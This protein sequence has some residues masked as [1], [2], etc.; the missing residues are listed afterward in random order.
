MSAAAL[1]HRIA[2]VRR[3]N[4]FYTQKIGVLA[5]AAEQPVSLTEARVL[6]SSR[7]ATAT[8]PSCAEISVSIPATSADLPVFGGAGWSRARRPR[9][10][11]GKAICH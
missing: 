9:W 2:T 5:S 10:I 6:T 7:F 3:F 4:R 8:P 1:E 11:A